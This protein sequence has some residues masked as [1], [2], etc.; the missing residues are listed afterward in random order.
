MAS[1][2]LVLF[3]IDGTLLRGAGPHH[4]LALVEGIRRAT[5]HETTLEGIATAGMLDHE[6]IQVMLQSA[7]A[8]GHGI[9]SVLDRIVRECQQAYLENC[10]EDL[11]GFRCLGV[12]DIIEELHQRG[13]VLGLVTGNLSQ[14]GWKKMELAGL[15]SYFAVGAFSE[16]ADSRSGLARVAAERA[17]ALELTESNANVSLI[18]DHPND[19]EAAKSNGF[20]A[21]AVGTG[22]V[23]LS[24]LRQAQ[25]D[26]LVKD[27]TELQIEELLA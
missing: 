18:G 7:G 22:V 21:V 9:R 10:A 17:V 8:G 3:D 16:D 24:E 2:N 14:I 23:P 13:A 26:I 25:P 4:K 20:R 11:T 1:R 19:I 6:L 15:R 12:L 27:L 5:G